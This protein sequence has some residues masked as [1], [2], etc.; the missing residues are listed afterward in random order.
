MIEH[1][2]ELIM[3]LHQGLRHIKAWFMLYSIHLLES[4]YILQ[5]VAVGHLGKIKCW[6]S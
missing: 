4:C 1:F 5:M 2:G 3:L 6:K